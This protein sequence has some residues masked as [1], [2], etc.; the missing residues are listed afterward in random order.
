MAEKDL[1][2]KVYFM[3]HLRDRH[4]LASALSNCDAY[5]HPNPREPFGIAPLE[6]M[7]CELP[8]ILPNQ[9]GVRTY[10]NSS[11][12]WPVSA[13]AISYTRAILDVF[14]YMEDR[15]HRLEEALKIAKSF[16]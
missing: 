11:N 2:G 8:V 13:D 6:A 5:L 7:A 15:N 9:G 1:P 4:Q 12:S 3:D 10:A 16:G 14:K